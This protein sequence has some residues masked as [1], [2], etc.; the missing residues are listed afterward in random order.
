MPTLGEFLDDLRLTVNRGNSQD[1][2]LRTWTRQAIRF[3][4]RNN[5]F[6]YMRDFY[7]VVPEPDSYSFS[8]NFID[9]P[10]RP[11]AVE[12]L[13]VVMVNGQIQP[14]S[15]IGHRGAGGN[16][17]FGGYSVNKDTI[18]FSGQVQ[19]SP[20]LL[21]L[22]SFFSELPAK[23]SETHPLLDLSDDLVKWQVMIYANARDKGAVTTWG[24]LRD[25]AL[26]TALISDDEFQKETDL[27]MEYRGGS[28]G[29]LIPKG[30]GLPESLEGLYDVAGLAGVSGLYLIGGP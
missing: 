17:G 22:A 5:T 26:R 4:E 1:Q 3:I 14:L 11:K 28:D 27:S 8:L 12:A 24:A 10:R 19:G 9:P 18:S 30:E 15:K 21:V 16:K 29:A 23:E 25:E 20:G 6:D 7:F 2:R 13:G